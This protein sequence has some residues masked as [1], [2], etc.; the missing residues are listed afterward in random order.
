MKDE[1][2]DFPAAAALAAPVSEAQSTPAPA[3]VP[4]P[5][6]VPAPVSASVPWQITIPAA[7]LYWGYVPAQQSTSLSADRYLIERSLPLSVDDLQMAHSQLP[8]GSRVM[9]GIEPARLR[10]C[11]AQSVAIPA[12]GIAQPPAL[13]PTWE[14]VPSHVPEFLPAD[15]ATVRQRLNLLTGAFEPAQRQRMRSLSLLVGG[16]CGVAMVGLLVIGTARQVAWSRQQVIDIQAEVQRRIA[17]ALPAA[18][19]ETTTP[20][21]RLIMELRRVDAVAD[22]ATLQQADAPRMLESMLAAVP[23]TLRIQV[24]SLTLANDRVSLRVRVAD[25]SAAD[26]LYHALTLAARSAKLRSD[27]LQVQQV[28]TMAVATMTFVPEVAR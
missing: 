22:V 8:D 21:E 6:P 9:I 2:V 16:L 1:P 3:L 7:Q 4:D 18:P 13:G 11:F 20:N 23:P 12:A 5:A 17:N 19:G 26:Q 27:P 24:E 15:V 25:L 28:D 10:Q 14:L